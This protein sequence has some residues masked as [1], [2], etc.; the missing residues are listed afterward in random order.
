MSDEYAL[1]FSVPLLIVLVK[2]EELP[3]IESDG[4]AV[5]NAITNTIHIDANIILVYFFIFTASQ[6]KRITS[7]LSAGAQSICS[8]LKR[9]MSNIEAISITSNH[10]SRL[11]WI[12][13]GNRMLVLWDWV[14]SWRSKS[15]LMRYVQ[16][17]LEHKLNSCNG[18]LYV[19]RCIF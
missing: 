7:L 6:P 9:P 3:V 14:I 10:P 8:E 19:L 4:K 13:Y 18:R 15:C 16:L 11:I 5:S 2:L 12:E 17:W 1:S